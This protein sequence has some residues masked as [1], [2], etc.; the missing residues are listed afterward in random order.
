MFIGFILKKFAV[1][2]LFSLS[3]KFL[4]RAFEYQ[5]FAGIK[6]EDQGVILSE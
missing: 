3:K 6:N 4:C 1:I 2:L 5:W